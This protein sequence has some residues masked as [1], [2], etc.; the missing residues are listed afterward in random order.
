MSL[1]QIIKEHF[2]HNGHYHIHVDNVKTCVPPPKHFINTFEFITW[3]K[4]C[5]CDFDLY[6]DHSKTCIAKYERIVNDK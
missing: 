2:C 5:K 6:K 4:S 3:Q 1:I